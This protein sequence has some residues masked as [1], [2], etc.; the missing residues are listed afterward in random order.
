VVSPI[1]LLAEAAF[2]LG[3]RD[4]LRKQVA[5]RLRMGD[6]AGAGRG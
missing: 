5:S 6:F 3:M 4:E 2:A 1:F